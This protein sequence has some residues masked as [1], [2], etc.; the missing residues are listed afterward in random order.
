[1]YGNWSRAE[2]S[3]RIVSDMNQNVGQVDELHQLRQVRAGC[4]TG[5]MAEKGWAVEEMVKK[6]DMVDFAGAP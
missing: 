6:P 3:A 5:A 2:F 1:M 4:P